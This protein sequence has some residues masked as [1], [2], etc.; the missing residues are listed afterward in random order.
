MCF[1]CPLLNIKVTASCFRQKFLL[2]DRLTLLF[3]IMGWKWYKNKE[4]RAIEVTF[5]ICY[6][7]DCS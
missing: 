4:S 5:Y 1:I 7:N 2:V 3:F 6:D